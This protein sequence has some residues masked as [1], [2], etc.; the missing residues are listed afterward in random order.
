MKPKKTTARKPKPKHI[1]PP[2]C[3]VCGAIEQL[4]SRELVKPDIGSA[5]LCDGCWDDYCEQTGA[6]SGSGIAADTVK[7][8]GRVRRGIMA[9]EGE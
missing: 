3:E 8:G 1:F 7:R 5:I 9:Q 2:F 4:E 6:E